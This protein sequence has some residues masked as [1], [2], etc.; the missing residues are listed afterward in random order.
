MTMDS[1][2]AKNIDGIAT[3]CD[4]R[5]KLANDAFEMQADGVNFNLSLKVENFGVL[6]TATWW[7]GSGERLPKSERTFTKRVSLGA[8]R[9]SDGPHLAA[10]I[11]DAGRDLLQDALEYSKQ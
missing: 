9:N 2:G 6:L 3:L 5:R 4:C 8:M 11:L 10:L 1:D 7:G